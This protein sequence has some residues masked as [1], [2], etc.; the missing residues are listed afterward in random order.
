MAPLHWPTMSSA[1]SLIVSR[2]WVSQT[3]FNILEKA[4]RPMRNDG[5]LDKKFERHIGDKLTKEIRYT[6][7]KP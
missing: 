2:S 1:H 6:E 5:S 4:M 7:R 3:Q